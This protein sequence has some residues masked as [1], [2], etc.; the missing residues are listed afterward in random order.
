MIDSN[1]LKVIHIDFAAHRTK[2]D[3]GLS[4]TTSYG[5]LEEDALKHSGRERIPPP[6]KKHDYLPDLVAKDEEVKPSTRPEV[7]PL[8]VIQP[9]GVSFNMNGNEIEWQKWKMHV[10]EFLGE[11]KLIRL[12]L[13]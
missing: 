2:P 9:K 7:K 4:A 10:G 8:H 6:S 13:T 1:I 12:R 11:I 3:G 5:P